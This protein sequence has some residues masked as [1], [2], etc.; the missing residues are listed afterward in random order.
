MLSFAS[1]NKNMSD[2]TAEMAL[3]NFCIYLDKYYG[4]KV[5]VILDEYDIPVREAWLGGEKQGYDGFTFGVG[6]NR[7][8]KPHEAI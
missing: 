7:K 1:V 3:N 5:I 4:K 8:S 6:G 2:E